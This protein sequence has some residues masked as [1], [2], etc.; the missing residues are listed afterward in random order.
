M[1]KPRPASDGSSQQRR[2]PDVFPGDT[3]AIFQ[4]EYIGAPSDVVARIKDENVGVVFLPGDYS[5]I[6][7]IEENKPTEDNT[8]VS[9]YTRYNLLAENCNTLINDLIR[10]TDNDEVIQRMG[11]RIFP[12]KTY[13][14][15]AKYY[16]HIEE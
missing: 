5:S 12:N 10:R 15:L 13:E 7:D 1:V 11:Y 9:H 2:R 14:A 4:W 3:Y 8:C 16:E 6:H